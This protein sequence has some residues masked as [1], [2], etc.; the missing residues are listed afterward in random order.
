M[1]Q[2]TKS[3]EKFAL[4]CDD[5][6]NTLSFGDKA[7]LIDGNQL[8]IKLEN[9]ILSSYEKLYRNGRIGAIYSDTDAICFGP[10]LQLGKLSL[11][12][13]DDVL[14][15]EN[16][17]SIFDKWNIRMKN[18]ETNSSSALTLFTIQSEMATL[19]HEP[20]DIEHYTNRIKILQ[21]ELM[22]CEESHISNLLIPP[23]LAEK[24]D[25]MMGELFNPTSD[26]LFREDFATNNDKTPQY[27]ATK[28]RH[29]ANTLPINQSGIALND[30]TKS[31]QTRLSQNNFP[32]EISEPERTTPLIEDKDSKQGREIN[33]LKVEDSNKCAKIRKATKTKDQIFDD[34]V[35]KISTAMMSNDPN[36][37]EPQYFDDPIEAFDEVSA[38]QSK[39]NITRTPDARSLSHCDTKLTQDLDEVKSQ[40]YPFA[41]QS[42]DTQSPETMKQSIST[43]VHPFLSPL[44]DDDLS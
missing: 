33:F 25:Q 20:R 43:H 26:E 22:D 32:G 4:F 34:L 8:D 39:D 23:N 14:C 42:H 15:Q 21:D 29:P 38:F 17:G 10:Y 13:T 12:T 11:V 5:I 44:K 3:L 24:F 16:S 28:F 40:L 6:K 41:T 27:G 37:T 36:E 35:T 1:S 31:K 18:I 9:P 7:K 2:L 19:K 30:C